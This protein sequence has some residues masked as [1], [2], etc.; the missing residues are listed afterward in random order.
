MWLIL[1]IFVFYIF[2]TNQPKIIVE[3]HTETELNTVGFNI[4]RRAE[5]S[6]DFQR[7]N[8]STIPS[9]SDPISGNSY[10]YTDDGVEAGLI[11]YYQLEDIEFDGSSTRHEEI[12]IEVPR[13]DILLL[14]L[15]VVCIII[16]LVIGIKGVLSKTAKNVFQTEPRILEK[17]H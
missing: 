1:G 13:N 8:E 7:I 9:S 14:V 11:Y 3:W 4:W 17:N 2:L 5:S 16:G 10:Y 6:E 15:A 12:T